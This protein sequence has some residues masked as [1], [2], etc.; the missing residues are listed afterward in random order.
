ME[1]SNKLS[2]RVQTF[3]LNGRKS[4]ATFEAELSKSNYDEL[5][6]NNKPD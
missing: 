1:S 4:F 3:Q 5:T 2:A 6:G